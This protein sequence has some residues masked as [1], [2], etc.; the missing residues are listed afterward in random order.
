MHPTFQKNH[1]L[2]VWCSCKLLVHP[3]SYCNQCFNFVILPFHR[4]CV[5]PIQLFKFY[6]SCFCFLLRFSFTSL[7][8]FLWTT[9]FL[10]RQFRCI[11][12][13]LPLVNSLCGIWVPISSNSLSLWGSLVKEVVEVWRN[14]LGCEANKFGPCWNCTWAIP[15]GASLGGKENGV[16]YFIHSEFCNHVCPS[17]S[18]HPVHYIP[19]L[20]GTIG[21]TN[22]QKTT[23]NMQKSMHTQ[24]IREGGKQNIQPLFTSI[25]QR[26]QKNDIKK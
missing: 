2:F 18:L 11:S 13:H 26:S 22:W 6:H 16:A 1:T 15:D 12:L 7:F 5:L 9:S 3:S 4:W 19:P 8:S 25:L 20:T 24:E 14:A 17:K 21:K 10:W 23:Q